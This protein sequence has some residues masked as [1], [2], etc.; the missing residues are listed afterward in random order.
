ME[1]ATKKAVVSGAYLEGL[2]YAFAHAKSNQ[3][4]V[5]R[6]M[7]KNKVA[8]YLNSLEPS[9]M[10]KLYHCNVLGQ[11]LAS[12]AESPGVKCAPIVPFSFETTQLAYMFGTEEA[13]LR[14]P[15]N[16]LMLASPIEEA[17][18]NG[19][20]A[21]VPCGSLDDN[22]TV[23]KVIVLHTGL[24]DKSCWED[25]STGEKTMWNA[26]HNKPLVWQNSNRPARRY[27][28][29]RYALTWLAARRN[30]YPDWEKKL[31]AGTSMWATPDK[32]GGY[33][34][35]SVLRVLASKIGDRA[36]LPEDFIAAGGFD[37]ADSETKVKNQASAIVLPLLVRDHLEAKKTKAAEEDDDDD[38]DEEEE[39]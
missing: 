7:F 6:K 29:L 12:S 14:S 2:D 37:D 13:A 23:W 26:I 18:D 5:T 21:I 24:L 34:R 28:Y 8:V 38:T 10:H 36:P 11:Y 25:P 19:E 1:D 9:S 17:L 33:L 20:I 3:P 15:R 22:P 39:E 31:P 4:Q 16:G 32:P 27:L 30:G 35:S